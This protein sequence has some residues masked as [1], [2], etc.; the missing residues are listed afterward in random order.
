MYVFG[1]LVK[2]LQTLTKDD[3][4]YTRLWSMKWPSMK[5]FST[6]SEA[7]LTPTTRM[8]LSLSLTTIVSGNKSV[9]PDHFQ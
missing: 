4:E 7:N 9:W 2:S 8:P 1:S 3:L 5:A 6:D